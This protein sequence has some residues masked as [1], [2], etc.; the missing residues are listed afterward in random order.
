MPAIVPPVP[1]EGLASDSGQRGD[2]GGH[3]CTSDE[4]SDVAIRL[5]PDFRTCASKMRVKVAAV[6]G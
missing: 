2:D 5:S 4:S 1:S 6:L 3:T